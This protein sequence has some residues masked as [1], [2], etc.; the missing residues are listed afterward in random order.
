MSILF[1]P[2]DR[3]RVKDDDDDEEQVTKT[4]KKNTHSIHK[5]WSF[6]V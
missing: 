5:F 4:K 1:N 3:I 2:A 6:F